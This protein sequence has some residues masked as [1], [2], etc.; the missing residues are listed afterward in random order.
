VVKIVVRRFRTIRARGARE[1]ALAALRLFEARAGDV[2][3]GRGPGETAWEYRG[4]LSREVQLSDGHLDRLTGIATTAAY[5]PRGVTDQQAHEAGR[6]G[7]TAIRDVR[8]SVGMAR[9]VAGLW[10]PQI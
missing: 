8:R 10:R 7:R 9:R 6:A 3:L 1:R 5:S 2:G 4:R